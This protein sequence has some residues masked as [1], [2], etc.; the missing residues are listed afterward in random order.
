M[1]GHDHGGKLQAQTGLQSLDYF[2]GEGVPLMVCDVGK[3]NTARFH[4]GFRK[5]PFAGPSADTGMESVVL[6]THLLE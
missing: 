6:S 5:M 1:D 4:K 2:V 3:N